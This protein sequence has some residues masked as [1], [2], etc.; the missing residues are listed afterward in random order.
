MFQ[1]TTAIQRRA[2]IITLVVFRR[3][4]REMNRRLRAAGALLTVL[5]YVIPLAPLPAKS[6]EMS[7][8]EVLSTTVSYLQVTSFKDLK[9]RPPIFKLAAEGQV[10][11]SGCAKSQFDHI[12][13][14]SYYCS[15]DNTI[16]L[17]YGQIEN[18]RR[19]YGDAGVAF[20]VFHE[21]AH[22]LQALN[23]IALPPPYNELFADCI[24]GALLQA[25][26]KSGTLK[27]DEKDALEILATA[28]SIGGGSE[29]GTSEQRMEAVTVG[30]TDGNNCLAKYVP[31]SIPTPA[32][33]AV[34][35][36]TS[37]PDSPAS[38]AQMNLYTRIAA[39]NTCLARAAGVDFDKAVGIA[40]ETIAQV[41]QG[42]HGSRIK[43]VGPKPLSLEYLRQGSINSAVIGAVEVCPTQ[44]PADVVNRVRKLLKSQ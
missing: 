4:Q 20:V 6:Q 42:Q 25:S 27:Y 7:L 39:V 34:A 5:G 15:K 33:P 31:K 28:Y 26:E 40:G 12:V 32:S 24:A 9:A 37:S 36:N 35:V 1:I 10:S 21:Y 23:G 18:I 43:Q 30:A 41:I 44:V 38:E 29:H 3:L 16:I 11:L 17:A 8:G 14:G 22:Y 13:T 19:R 2:R